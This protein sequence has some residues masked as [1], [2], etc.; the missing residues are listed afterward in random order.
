MVLTKRMLKYILCLILFV[1]IQF[2]PKKNWEPERSQFRF[3]PNYLKIYDFNLKAAQANLM[4]LRFIA[5]D[6]E[7]TKY[8][9]DKSWHYYLV[10]ASFNLNPSIQRRY[11]KSGQLLSVYIDDKWGAKDIFDRG[12]A[13][14]PEYWELAYSA[15]Y[16]YMEEIKDYSKAADLLQQAV[17]NGAKDWV[18]SLVGKL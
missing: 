17:E 5:A 9:D 2:L 13:R 3:N 4:W 11:R 14:F 7:Y 1:G 16:H 6:L 15:G 12:V 8:R 10:D 18:M